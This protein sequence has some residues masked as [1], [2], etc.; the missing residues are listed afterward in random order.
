MYRIIEPEIAGE[1]GSKTIINRI[2][3]PPIVEKLHYEFNGWL[4]DDILES[5]PCYI[6]TKRLKNKI[7]NRHLSGIKFDDV[8]VTTSQLF[9]DLYPE[10]IIPKFYWARIKGVPFIDDFAI[11]SDSKLLI[12]ERPF[13][14]L[15]SCNINHA[16]IQEL[17]E[18]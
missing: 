14:V 11:T 8:Y 12:S 5:F 3:D 4:G 10:K 7:E 16:I 6:M 1:L 17:K 13:L 2:Y 18:K 9:N 15:K